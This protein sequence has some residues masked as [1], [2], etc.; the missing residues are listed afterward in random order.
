MAGGV[1]KWFD[2]L[3]TGANV[4]AWC[5]KPLAV[6]QTSHGVHIRGLTVQLPAPVLAKQ[7]KM[8]GVLGPL[9]TTWET[10]LKDHPSTR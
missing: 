4:V 9:L 1:A 3:C 10:R 7:W 2:V 5:A 8:S 6:M